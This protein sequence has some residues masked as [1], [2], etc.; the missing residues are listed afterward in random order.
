MPGLAR[1]RRAGT[2]ERHVVGQ[3]AQIIS[4]GCEI[5]A[6]RRKCAASS[7]SDRSWL[8]PICMRGDSWRC[9]PRASTS[10]TPGDAASGNSG[11]PL[12]AAQLRATVIWAGCVRGHGLPTF[13]D[14]PYSSGEL[15]KLGFRKN[16]PEMQSADRA[17][18]AQALEAGVVQTQTEIQQH[19]RQMLKLS[20]CMRAHGITDFPDPEANGA[21]I[22]SVSVANN[23]GYASAARTCAA[24]PAAKP[25]SSG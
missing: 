25:P 24:P 6:A 20:E 17:C 2:E 23:A 1:S 22:N 11:S 9:E 12:T 10:I 21:F 18:H 8:R 19:L 13:P 5:L 16:S 14:P 3:A 15:N 4:I 7:D